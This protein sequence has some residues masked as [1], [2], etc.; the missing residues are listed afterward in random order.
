ML[1]DEE[2]ISIRRIGD[3]CLKLIELVRLT[4]DE[5]ENCTIF[6]NLHKIDS[7]DEKILYLLF[8]YINNSNENIVS[9]LNDTGINSN[10][11]VNNFLE[12][13][14]NVDE[15]NSDIVKNYLINNSSLSII[16]IINKLS[17][18]TVSVNQNYESSFVDYNISHLENENIKDMSI[19]NMQMKKKIRRKTLYDKYQGRQ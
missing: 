6:R 11:V 4:C 5:K 16:D 13:G 10:D 18:M 14:I 17:D 12:N 1:K 19:R 9:I 7:M 15:L 3:C 8:V 2:V